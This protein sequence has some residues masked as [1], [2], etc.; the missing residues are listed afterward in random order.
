VPA[1][2][3]SFRVVFVGCRQSS[4]KPRL[5]HTHCRGRQ[6]GSGYPELIGEWSNIIVGARYLTMLP[7][8][9]LSDLPS[10]AQAAVQFG[11]AHYLGSD[12]GHVRASNDLSIN[13]QVRHFASWLAAV[14]FN[15]Q[16][17]GHIS[18]ALAIDLIAAYITE[19]KMGHSLPSKSTG[20]LGKQSL[21]N[22]ILA[23]AQC[24]T[25]IAGK[26]CVIIDPKTAHER[27]VHIHPYLREIISQRKAWSKP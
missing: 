18:N 2:T 23:S 17:A 25:L 14:G 5:A 7:A 13:T 16:S 19:V 8:A 1:T 12:R 9:D 26:P 20:P 3:C 4:S 27:Q 6:S 10:P 15:Q 24:L 11:R 21:R 22:Y